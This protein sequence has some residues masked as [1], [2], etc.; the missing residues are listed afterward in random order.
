MSPRT[1]VSLVKIL[2]NRNE[3]AMTSAYVRTSQRIITIYCIAGETITHKLS[4]N[5]A[6]LDTNPNQMALLSSRKEKAEV[7]FFSVV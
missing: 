4:T 6:L 3:A 1:V 7:T 5:N 2:E